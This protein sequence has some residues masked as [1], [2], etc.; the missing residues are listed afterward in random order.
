M[1]N[2]KRLFS[3][4]RNLTIFIFL[5]ILNSHAHTFGQHQNGGNANSQLA[6]NIYYSW[7]GVHFDTWLWLTNENDK[8]LTGDFK[9]DGKT[10]LIGLNN[11]GGAA[12]V[13]NLDSVITNTWQAQTISSLYHFFS[14]GINNHLYT[15][16]DFNGDG[17]DNV[18][19]AEFSGR[20]TTYE[21]F[22]M[23]A[24]PVPNGY[25]WVEMMHRNNGNIN[26]GDKLISG[27][28]DGDGSSETMLIKPNSQHFTMKFAQHGGAW[29]WDIIS[30]GTNSI[31]NWYTSSND[32]FV[33]GDFNGNGRDEIL[34]INPSGLHHTLSFN[35]NQWS[36]IEGDSSGIIGGAN[37]GWNDRYI[38]EDFDND[39]RD[40]I[41]LANKYHPWSLRL[42]FN[43][44]TWQALNHN[45]GNDYIANWKNE[46]GDHMVSG[47]FNGDGQTELMLFNATNAWHTVTF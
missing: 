27:D 20:Y 45:Q 10:E 13:M 36:M 30:N 32:E 24:L 43:N 15:T 40:E 41:I 33:V 29:N 5:L 14:A 12:T 26:P 42:G 35:N 46:P 1:F 31:A 47:D 21:Y 2:V 6:N 22:D 7:D 17:K 19:K 9:G 37:I 25:L 23:S 39:G 8:Y 3:N 28:F 16:G 34:A 38:S 11:A 18:L 4:S 44:N